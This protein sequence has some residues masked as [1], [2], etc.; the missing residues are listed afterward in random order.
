MA[1][2]FL[3]PNCLQ[4][5]DPTQANAEMGAATKLWQHKRCSTTPARLSAPPDYYPSRE[6]V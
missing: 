6:S 3:C 5:V 2:T 4:P 1:L